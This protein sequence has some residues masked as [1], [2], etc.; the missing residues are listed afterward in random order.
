[1]TRTTENFA[2]VDVSRRPAAMMK[3]ER[4]KKEMRKGNNVNAAVNPNI[5][6]KKFVRLFLYAIIRI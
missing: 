5:H 6:I 4:R 1:M 2:F 3:D